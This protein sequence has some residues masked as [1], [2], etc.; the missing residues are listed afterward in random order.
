MAIALVLS[1]VPIVPQAQAANEEKPDSVVMQLGNPVQKTDVMKQVAT[2]DAN[3]DKGTTIPFD[4]SDKYSNVNSNDKRRR[5]VFEDSSGK[6]TQLSETG[7]NR[8]SFTSDQ[9]V[10]GKKLKLITLTKDNNGNLVK[11]YEQQ[12]NVRFVDTKKAEQKPTDSSSATSP[13]AGM[14]EDGSSWSFSNGLEYTFKNTGF[15]FLDNTTMNLGAIRLPLQY[16]HKSDGTTLVGINCSPED[17][18]FFKA[19]KNGNVWQKYTIDDVAKKTGEMDKGWSGK[20]LGTWGGKSLDWNICGYM[21]FNT[22]QPNAP[23]AVNLIISSGMKAEGHAQYLIFTGTLTFTVGGKA[24]LTGKLTPGKGVEGK[25]GLGA[26]AGLELYIGLGLQYVASVGAYGKGQI[27]IDFQILPKMYL[28]SVVLS[29]QCGAKAK[30]FGFTIYTWKILEGKK[31]LYTHDKGKKVPAAPDDKDGP[32]MNEDGTASSPLS[33]SA[34][35]PYPVDSREYL[36]SNGSSVSGQDG[37]PAEQAA[38]NQGLAAQDT[39]LAPSASSSTILENIYDETEL[40][41]ATSSSG[42][43]MVYVADAKQ[44]NEGDTRDE[45][46]RSVVVYKR[47]NNDGT[48]SEPRI[49]D[50]VSESKEFADYCPTITCDGDTCYVSWL[51]ANSK[52]ED[53][54]SIGDV[55]K[56][57]DIKLATITKGDGIANDQIVVEKVASESSD[58]GSMPAN[59]KVVKANDGLYVGW[60]TNQTTGSQGEVLGVSGTHSIRLFKKA[61]GDWT[62][63]SEVTEGQSGAITSFDVGMYG[64]TAACTWSLDEQFSSTMEE[65]TLNGVKTLASSSVYALIPNSDEVKLVALGATNAQFA[66]REGNDVLTYAIRID[67]NDG[68]SNPYLSIQSSSSLGDAGETVLDGSVIYLPTPYYSI[69]GDLGQGRAGNISFMKSGNGTSDIQALVTTGEGNRDWTSIVEAT[70]DTNVITDY[71]ATYAN[72]LPLFVYASKQ[73]SSAGADE[74]SAQAED[75]GAVD[76][77]NTTSESL[78]HLSVFDIDYDEYEV[79]SGQKMPVTV[80]FDNDGMLDVSGVNLWMLEDGKVSNVASIDKEVP[81]DEEGN[82]ISFEYTIPAKDTFTKAREFTLYAAP[83]GMN[84][85]KA[86]IERELQNG[87]AQTVSLGAASLSLDVD[88]QIVDDQESVIATVKNDGIVPHGAQLQFLDSD[89]G[90]MLMTMDV[91]ELGENEAFTGVYDAPNGYFQND[92]VK[93]ITIT[94]ENDGTE[95]D[96]YEINN[97]EFVNTWEIISDDETPGASQ[98]G[99]F[100]PR[101]GDPR[102]DALI[103]ALVVA[104]LLLVVIAFSA[105]CLRRRH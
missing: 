79:S 25:F 72:G 98:T 40:T 5:L 31:P 17:E 93:N 101:T 1:F 52:I 37:A 33:V 46:N 89:T 6:Q 54:A 102:L 74:L 30:L 71:C 12:L 44:V 58:T 39:A 78:K 10:M 20:K 51:A 64:N 70:A 24:M 67:A 87:A 4:V 27:D 22:K 13:I 23:R 8:V 42:P 2:L 68:I 85:D 65:T 81:L 50:G 36:D 38:S 7:D 45:Y 55:G 63:V 103:M 100:L 77:S 48:W 105:K 56:K 9:I 90:E 53:G 88:H 61:G 57:L 18:A 99:P 59:P 76:L 32:A 60:Y 83:K 15:K 91:P 34:D 19:V 26:Y 43:V 84:V 80:F 41:C 3:M 69:T 104:A 92:G 62:K 29:G 73:S 47:M 97:T 49:I 95:S 14:S 82:S 28:D 86:K 75:N 35:T 66:K 96:G 11:R 94:L 16:K 21:E